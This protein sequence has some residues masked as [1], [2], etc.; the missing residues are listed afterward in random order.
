[1]TGLIG[2]GEMLPLLATAASLI[3]A[4]RPRCPPGRRG[5]RQAADKDSPATPPA[6]KPVREK[7]PSKPEPIRTKPARE[8]KTDDAAKEA[9]TA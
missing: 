3:A 9:A 5:A 1:M 7:R 4:A 6:R 8:R 2:R